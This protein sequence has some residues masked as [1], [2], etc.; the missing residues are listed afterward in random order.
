MWHFFCVAGTRYQCCQRYI[1]GSCT[2]KCCSSF[3]K[4]CPW[5]CLCLEAFLC[6]CF[7]I[8]ATRIYIQEERQ[9]KSP[10]LRCVMRSASPHT[11]NC[12]QAVPREHVIHPRFIRDV[13]NT[14]VSSILGCL[15]Y[16]ISLSHTIPAFLALLLLHSH[17][18]SL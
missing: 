16:R 3:E 17:D 13:L 11:H 7:A 10:T 5:P 1:C 9:S 15:V 8:S 4:S 12:F 14:M 2:E 18:G 6:E